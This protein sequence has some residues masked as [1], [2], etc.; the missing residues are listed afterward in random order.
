MIVDAAEPSDEYGGEATYGKCVAAGGDITRVNVG[1]GRYEIVWAGADV[2]VGLDGIDGCANGQSLRD[3]G[4]VET[5][6]EESGDN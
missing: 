3:A 6:F 1:P 2:T 5:L 4:T